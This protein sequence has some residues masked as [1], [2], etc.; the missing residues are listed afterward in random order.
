MKQVE[1]L[2]GQKDSSRIY[3]LVNIRKELKPYMTSC[4]KNWMIL[5]E[6]SDITEWCRWHF[7]NIL[8]DPGV[9]SMEITQELG[10]KLEKILREQ[11]NGMKTCLQQLTML[12]KPHK[13]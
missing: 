8:R 12:E 2:Q 11:E 13:G 5:N 4:R 9:L 3:R 1:Q 6:P 7:Q 10:E